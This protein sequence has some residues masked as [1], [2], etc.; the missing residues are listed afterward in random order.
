[1]AEQENSPFKQD[2][3]QASR[4]IWGTLFGGGGGGIAQ[5]FLSN[6]GGGGLGAMAAGGP[7]GL[8]VGMGMQ[9]LS[10]IFG[11][12]SAGKQK[13]EAERKERKARKEVKRLKNI[14][15][16]LDTSNPFLN[17]ENTMED[18][19]INQKQ[20]EFQSQQFQQSQANIM[21]GLRGAAGGSG[22]AA[23]AQ[24]L[25]Q[26]GQL[27]SQQAAASIG[28]QE[29]QNQM[30]ERQ[31]AAQLQEKEIQGEMYSR[32]LKREQ[33]T[34]MLGMAQQEQAAFA[35]QAGLA[36]EAKWGAI[37]G[38]IDNLTSMIPGVGG[39]SGASATAY[40]NSAGQRINAKGQKID[41]SGNVITQ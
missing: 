25:A 5:S 41:A 23:L 22:I 34:T 10:G 24:S 12:I 27:A 4:G 3:P 40:Y 35:E 21:Q 1:M 9:A 18:L 26:Q 8:A 33:A 31:M 20:A 29:A 36:Q 37:S 13:K 14:Y 17:M 7:G 11:A 6:I 15:A 28:Q 38:G 2:T 19:T 32:D 30:A 16:N 39:D